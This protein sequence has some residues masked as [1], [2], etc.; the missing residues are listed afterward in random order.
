MPCWNTHGG[1]L[2]RSRKGV[3]IGTAD[4]G[5][6]QT[7][8]GRTRE[9]PGKSAHNVAAT[10]EATGPN[11]RHCNTHGTLSKACLE[12]AEPVPTKGT[13]SFSSKA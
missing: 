11:R 13:P 3:G 6:V 12:D 10:K 5:W 1:T 8:S 2:Q 7:S 4:A 9:F